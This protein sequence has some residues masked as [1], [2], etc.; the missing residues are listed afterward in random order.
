[1][2]DDPQAKIIIGASPV[3]L[4]NRHTYLLF[5][6][7]DGQQEVI[8]GGPDAR[9][10][11]ND[12][13]NLAESTVLGS[14][15]FGNLRVDNAPYEPPYDAVYRQGKNGN[16]E[17]LHADKANLKDPSLIRDA[18][19]Q[20]IHRQQVAPDWPQAGEQHE[21]QTVWTGTEAELQDKLK[22]ARQAGEQIN[23]AKLEYSPL[24][25]N[26]NGVTS[27]LMKAAD[28]APVLPQDKNH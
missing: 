6:H 1:M 21:R 20:P 27:N 12:V 11:G 3:A 5:Q 25:N 19:G 22:A 7:A 26:S 2:S 8:R 24:H 17:P 18:N 4:G 28:V 10:E 14:N 15:K 16:V 13:A 23:D 9:S